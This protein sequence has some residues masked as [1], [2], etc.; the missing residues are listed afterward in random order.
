MTTVRIGLPGGA[1]IGCRAV[2]FDL[3]GVLVDSLAV[4][5]RHLREWAIS[6]DLDP[7]RVVDMSPGRTNA[8]LVA[9]VAPALDAS[10]EARI[11]TERQVSD[12]SGITACPGAR[13]LLG[14]L[15][16]QARAVVTSGS[17][18]I[19]LARLAAADL[20]LPEVIVTA[21][22]VRTGKPDPEC[23]LRAA[24]LLDLPA[25]DCVVIEDAEAGLAAARAAR[26][27]TVAVAAP[28]A[29]IAGACDFEVAS[30]DEL[31][32]VLVPSAP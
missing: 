26:M 25:A 18:G 20:P 10:A 6:R 17:R 24:R 29:R 9:L 7:S 15:P 28:G 14:A 2:L 27:R 30:V 23:Y 5:A 11:M 13:R 12:T 32:I 4:I 22:D 1:S 31:S 3:D 16:D 8:D 21:E 19:A